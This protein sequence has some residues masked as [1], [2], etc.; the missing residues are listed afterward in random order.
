MFLSA[1]PMKDGCNWLLRSSQTTEFDVLDVVGDWQV[2][3]GM[4]EKS[5]VSITSNKCHDK[6]D[7]N[8]NGKCNEDGKCDCDTEGDVSFLLLCLPF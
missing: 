7:C 2:W 4:I 3:T 1:Y 6:S 5:E 8:L